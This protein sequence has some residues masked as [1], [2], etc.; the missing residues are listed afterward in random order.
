MKFIRNMLIVLFFIFTLFLVVIWGFYG[1]FGTK[2]NNIKDYMEINEY[3]GEHSFVIFPEV[4]PDS[5]KEIDYYHHFRDGI[6][7]VNAQVFL[8]ISLSELDFKLELIRLKEVSNKFDYLSFE[9]PAYV[10]QND[11]GVLQYSLYDEENYTIYYIFLEEI[12]KR[13]VYFDEGLLPINYSEGLYA[14]W[15]LTLLYAM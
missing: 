2:S 3:R 5:A 13:N 1:G 15:F 9:Y 6:G 12:A 4:L 10:Y 8:S 14:R 7:G 11:D